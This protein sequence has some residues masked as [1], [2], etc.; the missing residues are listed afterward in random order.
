[1][2]PDRK[3]EP[4]DR[5]I[6]GMCGSA[7]ATYFVSMCPKSVSTARAYKK[8]DWSNWALYIHSWC[9]LFERDDSDLMLFCEFVW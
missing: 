3:G 9:I 2:P 1:M 6:G 4:T 7:I 8:H 5:T